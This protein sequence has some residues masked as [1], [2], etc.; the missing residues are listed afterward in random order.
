MM[1]SCHFGFMTPSRTLLQRRPGPRQVESVQQFSRDLR[2]SPSAMRLLHVI[3][4]IRAA[5]GGP[6]EAVRGL[7]AVHLRG[8]HFV[9]VASLDDPGDHE[10]R[11][12]PLPLH[13]VGPARNTYSFAPLFVPWL[14]RNRTR[15][16][17]VIINGL[18]Q[19]H[20]FGAWRALRGSTTPYYVFPHGMLDPWFKRSFPLKHLKKSLYWPWA[21][22]R[23]LR[24]A[25]AVLFTCEKEKLLAPQSFALYRA[26]SLVTGLGT[27]SPPRDVDATAFLERY[28]EL[29]GK[30]LLLFMGRLHPKK[31]CDLLLEAYAATIAKDPAWR[32]V[33]AGPD[34]LQWQRALEARA[35]A[36]RIADRVVW[37]GM[38]RDTLKWSAL[39]AAEVFAL[40]SHQ[41][42]FGI[43]VA[44]SL[45]CGVPVLISREVNIWHEIESANAGLVA[46]D[47]VAGTTELLERWQQLPETEQIEM[48]H[49]ARQCF[50]QHFDIEHSAARLLE[51][52][53][54]TLSQPAVLS[55]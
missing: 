9:E 1:P 55:P 20:S 23:V 42:N 21:D 26:N 40:P 22:Y 11:S 6:V 41:E 24:D 18:W 16:D 50:A 53:E 51:T 34:D 2:Q 19:Y 12:F 49:N 32:L 52:I 48:R 5:G 43:A 46:P 44:E 13:A 35:H 29:R 14:R 33:F 7:S 25:R 17:A 37:T 38:L 45:A 4:S 8:G 27:T 54:S 28:P 36:L 15:Y 10:V 31:G 47:T 3:A 39:A 30:R